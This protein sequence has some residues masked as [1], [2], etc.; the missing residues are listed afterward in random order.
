MNPEIQLQQVT[1]AEARAIAKEA[2][3]WGMHPVAIYHLRY[4]QAQNEKSPRFSGINRLSWYRKP[5]TASDHFVTTPNATTLYGSAMLDLSKEP[6]VLTVPEIRDRYWS[7]QFADNYAR[8]WPVMAGSQF[9]APGPLR[10]LLVGP[11]WSGKIP[12]EFVGAEIMKS[13][14]DFSVAGARIA[15]TDDTL[16]ELKTVN[17]IQDSITLMSLSQWIAAGRKSVKADVVPLTKGNYPTYPGMD[18]VKEPGRLKGIEFLCWVSLILNDPTFTKQTDSQKEIE[19]FARFARL[20]LQA[21]QAFDP[22][23]LRAEIKSAIEAGIEDGHKDM[24]ALIESDAGL[25]MNGWTLLT[26]LGY[27]NTD[28]LNRARWGYI[29]ILAPIPCGSHTAA[30][31]VKDSMGHPLSGENRYSMT[32][33][34][35]NLPPVTEFW[36]IPLYDC[37]GYFVDNPINRYSINSYMLAGGKLHTTDGKL[38]IYVQNEEPQDPAQRQNWLPAPK[39]EFQFTARFYGPHGPLI[40]GSYNMPGVTRVEQFVSEDLP[41]EYIQMEELKKWTS[42]EVVHT[43]PA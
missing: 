1:A 21:G 23:Q 20:G 36:E 43:S 18:A 6:V 8:W 39:G 4:N 2:F 10:R 27:K 14:S 9:S 25:Q 38:T 11:N 13:T 33:E 22:D 5:M 24:L 28:W 29:A 17:A 41:N 19:A 3:L 26:D 12:A 30:F 31:C 34:T 32:F 42:K 7:I 35:N 40:D 15:L 37:E 16:E